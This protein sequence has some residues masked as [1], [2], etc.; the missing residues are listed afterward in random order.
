M[1]KTRTYKISKGKI[2]ILT[3]VLAAVGALVILFAAGILPPK[4]QVMFVADERAQ[5]A[6][7]AQMDAGGVRDK[8]QQQADK[9]KFSFKINSAPVFED[10]GAEGTLY[11][12]NPVTNAYDMRV[13]IALDESGETV[14]QTGVISP[15]QSIA[16]DTLDQPLA[17]G[18]HT[19]TA[20]IVALDANTGEETGRAAAGLVINVEG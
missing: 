3:A 6:A 12:E 8:L 7:Y 16:R 5:D 15:G 13:E 19:A 10:G 2:I 1:S 4:E 17:A 11:I 9:S 14:Y 18:Q 20:T